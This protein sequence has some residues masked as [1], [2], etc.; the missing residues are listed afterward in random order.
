MQSPLLK[1]LVEA[2]RC[3]P[4]VGQRT[5]QRMAFHVLQRDRQ[6]GQH[7]AE[8]LAEAVEKI[9][10]CEQCRTLSEE[11]LCHLCRDHSRDNGQLCVV[12]SPADILAL[13]MATG[14]RGQY[15]VLHGHLSP[16]DGIGPAELR[17]DLLKNRLV[18]GAIEEL[19]IALSPGIEAEATSRYL[20]AMARERRVK[21]SRI[22]HGVPMG[23]ELEFTDPGTLA[24]AFGGR[25]EMMSQESEHE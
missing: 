22:A 14:F 1:S 18:S 7:L 23:G 13:E 10:H 6:G 5:A 3:L 21:A 2:F 19:I 15:F 16:L 11:T 9:G 25:T 20:Q 12:E 8:V 24:H 4:G 17:L